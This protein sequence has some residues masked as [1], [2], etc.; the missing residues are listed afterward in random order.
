MIQTINQKV[1][2]L[3]YDSSLSRQRNPNC[4]TSALIIIKTIRINCVGGADG[5]ALADLMHLCRLLENNDY[6]LDIITDFI[7]VTKPDKITLYRV[8]QIVH[9][10]WKS[11]AGQTPGM[12][13]DQPPKEKDIMK[14]HNLFDRETKLNIHGVNLTQA[15]LLYLMLFIAAC[16]LFGVR[17]VL[18]RVI[19]A[20]EGKSPPKL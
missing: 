2:H 11:K 18:S 20:K 6:E 8:L 13:R 12:D 17:R 1:A 3:S 5:K 10:L 15:T 14:Y 16:E 9:A 7:K 4:K 19:A